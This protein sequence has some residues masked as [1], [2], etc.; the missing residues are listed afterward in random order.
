MSCVSTRFSANDILRMAET[1]DLSTRNS[2]NGSAVV[3]VSEDNHY[4]ISNISMFP[5]MRVGRRITG[6]DLSGNGCSETSC[7]FVDELCSLT[8]LEIAYELVSKQD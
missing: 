1:S 7:C 2:A 8:V 4:K 6:Y 3:W 5:R